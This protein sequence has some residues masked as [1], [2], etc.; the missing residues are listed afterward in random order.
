M[1]EWMN[2]L[3]FYYVMNGMYEWLIGVNYLVFLTVWP[4][5]FN[6]SVSFIVA[7]WQ[8]VGKSKLG[9]EIDKCVSLNI[10]A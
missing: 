10:L 8:I 5:C 9:Y 4:I 2:Y 3:L 1:N 6:C 7:F